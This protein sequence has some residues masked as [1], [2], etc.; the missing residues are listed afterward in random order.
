MSSSNAEPTPVQPQWTRKES[1]KSLERPASVTCTS[2]KV[3]RN[4]FCVSA[5]YQ[6]SKLTTVINYDPEKYVGICCSDQIHCAIGAMRY[7]KCTMYYMY[8]IMPPLLVASRGPQYTNNT[9][10]LIPS[11]RLKASCT[12]M[13]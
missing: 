5:Q 6:G 2:A 1:A 4:S 10:T 12:S 8:D 9:H 7:V 3:V 11:A 13:F